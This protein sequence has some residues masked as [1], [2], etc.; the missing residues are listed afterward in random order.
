[1]KICSTRVRF[2]DL[3]HENS[4]LTQVF[5]SRL[6]SL[7]SNH[8]NLVKKSDSKLT[9]LAQITRFLFPTLQ[10]TGNEIEKLERLKGNIT[11][12]KDGL[13]KI[14]EEAKRVI[15]NQARESLRSLLETE[16][17]NRTTRLISEYVDR[18]IDQV[19]NQVGKCQPLS[20]SYNATL[21]AVCNQG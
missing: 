4:S 19:E 17:I 14:E 21:V 20:D 3:S 7:R 18:V 12:V 10:L 8:D 15:L 2:I 5:C 11:D 16:F 1:M 13:Q 6:N 9:Q